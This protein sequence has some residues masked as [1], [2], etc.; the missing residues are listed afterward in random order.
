MWDWNIW[1]TTFF[2][3]T[4]SKNI[5]GKVLLCYPVIHLF[6]LRKIV[7]KQKL[8]EFVSI[9]AFR[10][11]Q[12]AS[13]ETRNIKLYHFGKKQLLLHFTIGA[14]FLWKAKMPSEIPRKHHWT[15]FLQ[16]I[17]L[18]VSYKITLRKKRKHVWFVRSNFS[19]NDVKLSSSQWREK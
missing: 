1:I 5:I 15:C 17:T 14:N 7:Q 2:Q 12:Y 16:F 19:K 13:T 3:N 4:N 8:K 6:A 18:A 10:E 9:D 11:N